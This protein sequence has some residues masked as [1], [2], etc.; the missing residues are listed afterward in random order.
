[1]SHEPKFGLSVPQVLAGALAAASA[2]VA[3]SWLGVAGTV[4]GAAVVSVVASVGTVIYGHSL[5][6]G[7]QRVLAAMPIRPGQPVAAVAA[8]DTAVLSRPESRTAT[9]TI[10]ATSGTDTIVL[11]AAEGAEDEPADVPPSDSSPSRVNWKTVAVSSAAML[12]IALGMLTTAEVITGRTALTGTGG[13]QPTIVRFLE[14][15]S[16]SDGQSNGNGADNGEKGSGT[17]VESEPSDDVPTDSGT[18]TGPAEPTEPAP[19]DPSPTEP[20]P[21]GPTEPTPT[22]PTPT[23][24]DPTEPSPTE[25]ETNSS[26]PTEPGSATSQPTEAPTPDRGMSL[27]DNGV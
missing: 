11:P 8:A 27:P 18:S 9:S 4:I 21:T 25:P 2:A 12:A 15:S 17:D 26:Q 1:M 7:S 3:S 23:E 6:R 20:D 5:E 10:S 24:P 22:E 14:G 13:D 19:T 16:A